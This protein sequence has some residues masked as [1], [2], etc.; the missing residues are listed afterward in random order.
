MEEI[1]T[2]R[3]SLMEYEAQLQTVISALATASKDQI[4]DLE[5]L[6]ANLEEVIHLTKESLCSAENKLI[7]QATDEKF[8]SYNPNTEGMCSS[9]N[10]LIQQ[11]TDEKSESCNPNADGL[12]EM[13]A[14]FA[15]FQAEMA[16]L[17]EGFSFST[18]DLQKPKNETRISSSDQDNDE[19]IM[20]MLS[21]LPGTKCRAPFSREWGELSYHNAIV[22]SYHVE[23]KTSPETPED[24]K[25]SVMFCNPICN[26]MK[27]CSF[28]LEG[29]CKF[30]DENCRYSHGE[31]IKLP[32]LR[33]FLDPDYSVLQR[34]AP[35]LAR[36]SDGLWYRARVEDVL[37]DHKYMV[38][39]IHYNETEVVDIE[40]LIPEAQGEDRESDE[41]Q[42]SDSISSSNLLSSSDDDE[43]E[44]V[45][46]VVWMSSETNRTGLGLWEKH[47]QGLW[48]KHTRG[49]GSQLMAKMGYVW[50]QGLGK[51]GEGRIEPV[52]AVVLP[53]GKSLDKCMELRETISS[54][55]K[56]K[57]LQKQKKRMEYQIC[58]GYN[59]PRKK[60]S[61]FDFINNKIGSPRGNFKVLQKESTNLKSSSSK[62]LNVESVKVSEEL[63]KAEKEIKHLQGS[64]AR[65]MNRDKVVHCQLQQKL[66]YQ[67]HH[68]KYLLT[69]EKAIQQE[70]KT[71]K[72]HHKLSC[73]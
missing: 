45:P 16:S 29:K 42:P 43:E 54:G 70:Q 40:E 58:Q 10:K 67:H 71:R 3:N 2:L 38:K 72:D 47:N 73:F 66:A 56:E 13:D 28:Y 64:I 19:D 37:D 48:E 21:S 9:V 62:R 14:E 7:Q 46:T 69:Q 50:G 59:H 22:L 5:E 61:V 4:S 31:R 32:E 51:A 35:C 23:Q 57:K 65:N 1:E 55:N 68:I 63:R 12:T 49:I 17:D 18:T 15:R 20:V 30:S 24:I 25:V 52:E 34:D 36:Y 60:K 33:E 6:K 44:E 11:T 27:P 26:A 39:Y 53:Q 41:L 8:E